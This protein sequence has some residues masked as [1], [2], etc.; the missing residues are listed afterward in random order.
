MAVLWQSTNFYTCKS[1]FNLGDHGGYNDIDLLRDDG[2]NNDDND[3]DNIV[4]DTPDG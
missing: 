3:N 4:N 2:N 1:K